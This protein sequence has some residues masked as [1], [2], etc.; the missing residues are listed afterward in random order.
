[1]AKF[2]LES[3]CV[4]GVQEDKVCDNDTLTWVGKYVPIFELIS[5]KLIEQPFVLTNSHPKFL[6]ESFVDDID[7]LATQRK[8]QMNLMFS[9][10]DTSKQSELNQ[11]FS[12]PI[13]CRCRIE[14]VLAFEDECIEEDEE[15]DVWTKFLQT[16]KY[17]LNDLQ[18][19]KKRFCNVLPVFGFNSSKYDLSLMKS[20]LRPSPC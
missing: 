7:G 15:Q 17:R 11:I 6:V 9:E 19:H 18:N 8:T 13:Q 5:S 1:M 2:E 4:Q 12:A 14:T 10:I 20:Y 16:Q 3:V